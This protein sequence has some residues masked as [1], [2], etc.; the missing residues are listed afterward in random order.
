MQ[1]QFADKIAIVTGATQG[2]GVAV[3]RLFAQRGAAGIVTCGRRLTQGQDVAKEITADTDVPVEFV[4]AD[5]SKVANCRAVVAA[6]VAKFG[7]MDILVNVAATTERGTILDTSE[8]LFDQMFAV[9]VKGPFFLMQ[10]TA[11]VMRAQQRPGA[12]V[13]IGSIAALAGQPF[14]AAYCA[15]KGA[16]VTLTKNTAFALMRDG[17]RVNCLNIGWM[18]TEGE[19]RIQ[20]KYH[21]GKDGWQEQAAQSMPFGR[22][23]EP[24]EVARAV[25]FLAST[26]SG[27]MTGEA[28]VFDQ[29]IPGAFM[30]QPVPDRLAD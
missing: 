29:V 10:E 6:C 15:S 9:N 17:I 22:L 3:A 26:E 16:I 13:N 2:L 20:R 25:A 7:R 24:V 30:A 11:K 21:G 28:F 4:Q 8:E 5:V 14:I 23:L 27:M 19:D 12:I 18:N 1:D